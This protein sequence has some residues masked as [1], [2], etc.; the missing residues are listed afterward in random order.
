MRAIIL[1]LAA[2]LYCGSVHAAV[3][4]QINYQGYLTAA[5]GAPVNATVSMVLNLYNVSTGGAAL[6]TETQSVTVTNGV[7]NLIVGSV[8]PLPL[9]F[10]V[11]Y[12]LGIKV[13]VDAEMAPRQPIAASAYAIRSATTG[14]CRGW[15]S[16]AAGRCGP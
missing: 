8:T 9:P 7:F 10:D 1:L 14:S 5:G 12:Y 15:P 6:Y 11:P 3:P 13:G 4:H 2:A 16:E